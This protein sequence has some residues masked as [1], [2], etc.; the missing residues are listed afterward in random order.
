MCIARRYGGRVASSRGV[1]C[2]LRL[3]LRIFVSFAALCVW[4]RP[5]R[6]REAIGTKAYELAG[7]GLGVC[8]PGS[9]A[10][11]H[12]HGKNSVPCGVGLAPL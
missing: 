7:L 5:L 2:T 1:H 3:S 9:P 4:Q 8:V 11:P 6:H 10:T 12:S